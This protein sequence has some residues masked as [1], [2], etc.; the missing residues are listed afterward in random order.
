MIILQDIPPNFLDIVRVFPGAKKRKGVVFAWGDRLYNPDGIDVPPA[1][2]AHEE[3][4]QL[5]QVA[6]DGGPQRWWDRYLAD[7]AFCYAE[8]LVAHQVEFKEFCAHH[9]KGR[10]QFLSF[11]A[12]RL[13]GPLYGHPV[14]FD[15]AK[16]LIRWGTPER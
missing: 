12:R 2:R 11:I 6:F 8:E 13:S 14:T 7:S 16:H 3:T 10:S 1:L 4:H 9:T 5:R 15:K